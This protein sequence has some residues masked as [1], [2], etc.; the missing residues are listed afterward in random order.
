MI[1]LSVRSLLV[2]RL[3]ALRV[4]LHQIVRADVHARGNLTALAAIALIGVHERRHASPLRFRVSG[5]PLSSLRFPPAW[6]RHRRSDGQRDH[7]H[8]FEFVGV[9]Y[10]SLPRKSSLNVWDCATLGPIA[11]FSPV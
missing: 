4:Q 1:A 7:I 2:E 9:T 11:F 3:H 6:V 8:D 5:A 10:M